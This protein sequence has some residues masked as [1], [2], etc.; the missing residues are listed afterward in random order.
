MESV[1]RGA[2]GLGSGYPCLEGELDRPHESD[3]VEECRALSGRGTLENRSELEV[4]CVS[5]GW[6]TRKSQVTPSIL[7]SSLILEIRKYR[8]IPGFH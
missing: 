3:C 6:P 4:T 7:T 2:R 8:G 5:A 1:G